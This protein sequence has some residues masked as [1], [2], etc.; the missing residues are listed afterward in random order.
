M[1]RDLY[2]A[3]RAAFSFKSY[4]QKRVTFGHA[5][6]WLYQFDRQEREAACAFLEHV[7]FFD[8]KQTIQL[9]LSAHARLIEKLQAD[10]ISYD[11]IIYI[12]IDDAGSS[13]A[14]ILNLL[15]DYAKLEAKGVTFLDS[16]DI[17]G[18]HK[19]TQQLADGAIIYVDDF[20]GSG[21]QFNDSQAYMRP[22]VIGNFSEFLLAACVCEEA[23]TTLRHAP[24]SIE[25][26]VV[27]LKSERPLLDDHTSFDQEHRRR[28]HEICV[29]M[30]ADF[31][32]A[33]GWKR[34]ATMVVFYRNTPDNCPL[35]LR[36][37]LG[38]RPLF[39]LLPRSTDFTRPIQP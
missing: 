9:L 22:F 4:R 28:V 23:K 37:C 29:R 33:L 7:I 13:S 11:K 27:H 5:W 6:R 12:Q 14:A 2:A 32:P 8:E 38:Q 3:A 1:L 39:G 26:G 19:A 18:I 36:G 16:R 21:S 17:A 24:I 30:E 20:I 25:A 31:Y 15:R 34:M 35:I 10:G